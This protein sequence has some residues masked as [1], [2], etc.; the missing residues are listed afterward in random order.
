MCDKYK[1]IGQT[2]YRRQLIFDETTDFDNLFGEYDVI[3]SKGLDFGKYKNGIYEQYSIHHNKKDLDIVRNIIKKRFPS[4]ARD[5]EKY[6]MDGHKLYANSGIIMR[7]EDFLKYCNFLFTIIDEHR[8][9]TGINTVTDMRGYIK[10]NFPRSKQNIERQKFLY[11]FLAE[12]LMTLF[13]LHNFKSIL[14]IPYVK[15]EGV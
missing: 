12:R 7:S 8:K 2:Q 1:Y 5:F 6:I 4:Y 13:V 10:R 9:I 11:G 3:I 14:E 15:Y